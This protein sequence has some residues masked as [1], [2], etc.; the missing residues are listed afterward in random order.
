[1]SLVGLRAGD[2]FRVLG[3][4]GQ[5][6]TDTWITVD[7]STN[8]GH[9]N[10]TL[11]FDDDDQHALVQQALVTIGIADFAAALEAGIY[12]HETRYR[13]VVPS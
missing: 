13:T 10:C 7:S 5:Y 4:S 8:T 11:T 1:M 6:D 12:M 3:V 9:L 2:R